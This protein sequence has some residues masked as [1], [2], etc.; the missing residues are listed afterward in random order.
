MFRTWLFIALFGIQVMYFYESVLTD[1]CCVLLEYLN[2]ENTYP[3]LLFSMTTL[4]L[5]TKISTQPLGYFL[6]VHALLLK[7]VEL[8]DLW[9][10]KPKPLIHCTDTLRML[11]VYSS[12]TEELF[13]HASALT[14][15]SSLEVRKVESS[16][17]TELLCQKQ[18]MYKYFILLWQHWD[19][20]KHSILLSIPALGFKSMIYGREVLHLFRAY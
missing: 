13:W 15:S 20:W 5:I 14:W 11:A 8:P 16:W 17:V 6:R 1:K 12:F 9:H 4:D 18:K 10:W 3:V 7:A 2:L 19:H